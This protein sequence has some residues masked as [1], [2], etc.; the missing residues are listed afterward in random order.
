MNTQD[1]FI[2]GLFVC[3]YLSKENLTA[4]KYFYYSKQ[5]KDYFLS[6]N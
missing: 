4:H 1:R 6:L 5:L 2:I 3:K